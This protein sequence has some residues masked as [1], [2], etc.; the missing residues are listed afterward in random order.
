MSGLRDVSVS[1]D[2]DDCEIL[3]KSRDYSVHLRY[4]GDWWV[5]DTVNDRGERTDGDAKL[6]TFPLTEKYLIWDWITAARPRLA[7]GPLGAQLY[8]EGYAAGIQV[9]DLDGAHIE[10]RMDDDRAIL[11]SGTAT[12]CSHIMLMSVDELE[13]VGTAS[14]R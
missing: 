1:T 9:A 3:F 6:S 11:I 2:C 8:K 12:I 14:G 4:D 5:V 7:S 13:L 10:L